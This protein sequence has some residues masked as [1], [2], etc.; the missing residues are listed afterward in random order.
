[1]QTLHTSDFDFELPAELIA[2][3]PLHKRD[4]SRMLVVKGTDVADKHIRDFVEYLR[5]GD[6]VVFNN[7]KVIPA[8]FNASGHE[9]TLH[10]AVSDK[11]WWGLCKKFNKINIGEILTL[12]DGSQVKVLDKESES[13]LKLEFLCDHV[14]AVLEKVGKMPLPPYMKR[15]AETEDRERYQTVYADPIGSMAAPTAGLH[16]TPELMDE[17]ERRGAKIVKI[18]LHVGAGTW[19]P[20]KTENLS[21]HKM[22]SE[23]C[24]ITPEQ[25]DI[26]NNAKRVIAVG[27]TSMRTLESAAMDNS[28]LPESQRNRRVAPICR[29]TDIFITPGY[30][31]GAV[32][33]LLTNFHLPKSTLFML[34]S[35]FAGLDEMKKAYAHAVAEKYRFFSYG[36]CCLLFKKETDQ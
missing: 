12:D 35:A 14:F 30:K 2:S 19:M 29:S 17:I 7:S 10:T 15:E 1:M 16:F 4:A 23:W 20:V 32:D 27:T 5:P 11:I 31:F 25:A 6:V 21:E 13:G 22:H 24:C 3:H 33:V 36:D 8:R 28:K 9:I 18:T 34:V 26:I